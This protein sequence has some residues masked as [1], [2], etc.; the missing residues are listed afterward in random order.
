APFAR[1]STGRRRADRALR[2]DEP[3][4]RA[5]RRDPHP[6]QSGGPHAAQGAARLGLSFRPAPLNPGAWGTKGPSPEG[7]SFFAANNRGSTDRGV[8]R[9]VSPSSLHQTGPRSA[10]LLFA[11]LAA[12]SAARGQTAPVAGQNVNMVSGTTWPG[13]DPYL[14]RQNEP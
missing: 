4:R 3:R 10:I 13:G 1:G 5:L 11:A 7:F 9:R 2:Q 12:A 8:A 6:G 14:Q